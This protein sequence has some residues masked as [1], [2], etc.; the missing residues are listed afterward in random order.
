MPESEQGDTVRECIEKTLLRHLVLNKEANLV[1]NSFDHIL[2]V[3]KDRKI[4]PKTPEEIE[5]A[6]LKQKNATL[7]EESGVLSEKNVELSEENAKL[8]AIIEEKESEISKLKAENKKQSDLIDRLQEM[9]DKLTKL[10]LTIKNKFLGK[11]F[12]RKALE[13]AGFDMTDR[14]SKKLSNG[15]GRDSL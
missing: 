15:E 1:L 6:N 8:Q 2:S 7:K 11:I 13:E 12:F 5:R 4:K 10:G 14:N 3:D 9:V